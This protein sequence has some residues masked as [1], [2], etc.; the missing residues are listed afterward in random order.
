MRLAHSFAARCGALAVVAAVAAAALVGVESLALPHRA[1]SQVAHAAPLRSYAA[2]APKPKKQ[3]EPQKPPP[4][5]KQQ[6]PITLRQALYLIRSTLMTLNDANRSGN[7]TVLRDLSAPGFQAKNSAADLGRIFADLRSR[8][9]DL[10][11]VAVM[12]PQLTATPAVEGNGML[13]LT[14]YFPTQPLRIA[15]DLLFQ[16]VDRNWRLFGISVQTQPA[17]PEANI[18]AAPKK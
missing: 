14:G 6:T 10:Y 9:V 11:A 1:L 18:S 5:Q 12:A 4:A 13:R 3:S 8:H 7:Y 17:P 16:N 15:F 2:H